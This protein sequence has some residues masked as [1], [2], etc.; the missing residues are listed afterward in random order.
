MGWK[1]WKARIENVEK[2]WFEII[3]ISSWMFRKSPNENLN[4]NFL[5]FRSHA[6]LIWAFQQFQ[7]ELFDIITLSFSTSPTYDFRHVHLKL[8]K[9]FIDSFFLFPIQINGHFELNW[10][11]NYRIWIFRYFYPELIYTF[12]LRFPTSST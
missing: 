2:L 7:S 4:N 6:F 9:I 1:C 12:I 5:S 3:N 8:F 11:S 10:I